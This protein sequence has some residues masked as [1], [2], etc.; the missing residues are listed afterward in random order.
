MK[1][2]YDLC[3]KA[4]YLE[5]IKSFEKCYRRYVFCPCF[6]ETIQQYVSKSFLKSETHT[7][8]SFQFVGV[9][10]YGAVLG[11]KEKPSDDDRYAIKTD[12]G[13]IVNKILDNI[14]SPI[15]NAVRIV[16]NKLGIDASINKDMR[17]W[18]RGQTLEETKWGA[19]PAKLRYSNGR[20]VDVYPNS[21]EY[22]ALGDTIT[23]TVK[24]VPALVVHM[25]NN[26]SYIFFGGGIDLMDID[27]PYQALLDAVNAV[28]APKQKKRIDFSAPSTS[29]KKAIGS[30]SGTV[31]LP[32]AQTSI[33]MPQWK[34][35]L[36]TKQTNK[37][38]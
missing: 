2:L 4:V 20:E 33:Q 23:P 21:V 10:P 9:Y 29:R 32:P 6:V 3:G 31:Q 8:K 24:D 27:T 16:N 26:T 22:N 1:Q 35:T 13:F 15:G 12:T 38:T 28:N 5:D 25:K 7:V 14:K 37:D 19:L 36:D 30:S 34:T 18:S 11:D 17:I